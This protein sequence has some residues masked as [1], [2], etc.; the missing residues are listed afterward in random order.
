MYEKLSITQIPFHRLIWEHFYAEE[1]LFHIVLDSK[2]V[3]P[4]AHSESHISF[5]CIFPRTQNSPKNYQKR[6]GSC[7]LSHVWGN[8]FHKILK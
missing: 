3:G 2:V 4:Q 8:I 1:Y 6:E 7:S 5:L